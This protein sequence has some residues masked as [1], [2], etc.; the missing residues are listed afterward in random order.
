MPDDSKDNDVLDAINEERIND[1]WKLIKGGSPWRDAKDLVSALLAHLLGLGHASS[2]AV[3][4]F[5]NCFTLKKTNKSRRWFSSFPTNASFSFSLSLSPHE[6][7][8]TFPPLPS[9]PTL[10]ITELRR[11]GAARRRAVR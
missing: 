8:F 5:E 4:F 1:A 9:S 10:F 11:D 6:R 3:C 2:S 7:H